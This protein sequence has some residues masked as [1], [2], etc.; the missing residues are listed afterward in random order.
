M[1]EASKQPKLYVTKNF[2]NWAEPPHLPHESQVLHQIKQI[3]SPKKM[4]T[5]RHVHRKG[6]AVACVTTAA[7][8]VLYRGTLLATAPLW[9]YMPLPFF[10]PYDMVSARM[11]HF[12]ANKSF[13]SL[14]ASLSPL[15][16]GSLAALAVMSDSSRRFITRCAHIR[17]RT[18]PLVYYDQWF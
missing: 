17:H 11:T 3:N 12:L 8:A 18:D 7:C 10:R 4:L 5:G 16:L 13:L 9:R 1:F 14:R 6:L 2:H 15:C